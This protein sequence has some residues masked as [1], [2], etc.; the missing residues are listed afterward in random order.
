MIQVRNQ[1][2]LF[3]SSDVQELEYKLNNSVW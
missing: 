2:S 3:L 1:F